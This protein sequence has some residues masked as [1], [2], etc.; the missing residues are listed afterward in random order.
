MGTAKDEAGKAVAAGGPKKR[1]RRKSSNGGAGAGSARGRGGASSAAV[2][3]PIE[4]ATQDVLS[5]SG[6]LSSELLSGPAVGE[7]IVPEKKPTVSWDDKVKMLEG[8][9]QLHG[10]VCVPK[11]DS[12]LGW[13]VQQCR[14]SHNAGKMPDEK[15]ERLE[16]LGFVWCGQAA[17][18]IREQAEGKTVSSWDDRFRTLMEF[19]E[20]HGHTCVPMQR[21]DPGLGAWA[22]EQRSLNNSGKL[23][24]ARK[25]KLVSIG[26]IFDGAEAKRV[27]EQAEGKPASSWDDKFKL[28]ENFKEQNGHTCVPLQRH[29][30]GLGCWVREQ[31][32]LFNNGKLQDIRRE[33]LTDL[34]FIFDGGEAKKVREQSEGKAC[35]SW[36]DK[37]AMLENFK[38]KHGHTCVPKQEAELGWWVQQCR[39]L[40][41]NSKLTDDKRER[42][43]AI[44][45]V[46]DGA[47]AKRVRD[48][49]QGKPAGTWDDKLKLLVEFKDQNGHT[50]VVQKHPQL[51]F[52][53]KEQRMAL[54]KGRLSEDRRQKLDD[55]GFTWDARRKGEGEDGMT[56][57][58]GMDGL[59]LGAE[60]TPLGAG[61]R[62]KVVSTGKKNIKPA[63][64]PMSVM[65]AHEAA[66]R[67][68]AAGP[69]LGGGGVV[70]TA[71]GVV[72]CSVSNPLT[73]ELDRKTSL[74]FMCHSR[75]YAGGAAIWSAHSAASSSQLAPAHQRPDVGVAEATATVT[76]VTS[77]K[78]EHDA[79]KDGAAGAGSKRNYSVI[80][81]AAESGDLESGKVSANG[82]SNKKAA[83]APAG[84]ALPAI[85][86][87]EGGMAKGDASVI[88]AAQELLKQS[89]EKCK[90]WLQVLRKCQEHLLLRCQVRCV[91]GGVGERVGARKSMSALES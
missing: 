10:H 36:N 20:V 56:S 80:D 73:D 40:Y 78:E 70:M 71:T 50:C 46:F 49:F 76:S 9:N 17:K 27:R 69:P 33:R 1:D 67:A 13:W 63:G 61:P 58:V 41:N 87:G 30:P 91:W 52:W 47:E 57:S 53:V 39:Q 2:D 26:F 8:F 16:K 44:G 59:G 55:I 79:D 31:R 23:Q 5:P 37:F 34:G 48:S 3:V 12:E 43:E 42:L 90:Y 88:K 82:S 22:K 84:S 29:D 77:V 51:G 83:V 74:D 21:H 65:L 7:V 24:D 81:T 6:A 68:A 54:N 18:R 85:S 45:F 28:L 60:G 64:V 32:S 66:A 14:Q 75:Q 86:E 89:R 35:H 4:Y 62:P 19:R 25:Q 38:E 15:R 11:H 72:A